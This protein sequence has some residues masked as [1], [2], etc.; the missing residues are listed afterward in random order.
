MKQ[1]T[2]AAK[3]FTHKRAYKDRPLTEADKATNRRKSRIRSKVEHPFLTLKR[4]WGFATERYRGL[5]KNAS[6]P[7]IL[8]TRS[9]IA[10]ITVVNPTI[11]IVMTNL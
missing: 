5:A 3:N 9:P 6:L 2:L 7:M 8:L 11:S 10:H 4:L 1:L